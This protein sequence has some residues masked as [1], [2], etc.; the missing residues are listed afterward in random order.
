MDILLNVGVASGGSVVA[1]EVDDSIPEE[2]GALVE[3]S[4]YSWT[5][6]PLGVD[7]DESLAVIKFKLP[8]RMS[9]REKEIFD[10]RDVDDLPK[11]LSQVNPNYPYELK[12][13]NIGG[14]VKLE[15]IIDEQGVVR[16]VKVVES[17]HKAFEKVAIESVKRTKWRPAKINGLPVLV[18]VPQR[19]DFNS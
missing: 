16:F 7:D 17:S 13:R 19:M 6:K 14:F 18:R 9:I 10:L 1:V 15:W 3:R 5:F 12:I 2:I 8:L 4:L 11:A